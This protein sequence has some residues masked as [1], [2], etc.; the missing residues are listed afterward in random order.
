MQSITYEFEKAV[1]I[2]I[3]IDSLSFLCPRSVHDMRFS[4]HIPWSI[5]ICGLLARGDMLC[6]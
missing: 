6:M 3:F 4:F 2:L 1:F 5:T